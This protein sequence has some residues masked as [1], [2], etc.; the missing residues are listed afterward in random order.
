MPARLLLAPHRAQYLAIGVEPTA[1]T[2]RA[3][4][5][6]PATAHK[7]SFSASG[8][9]CSDLSPR[10][11]RPPALG[12][13]TA[14]SRE[15]LS[16][17]AADPAL[18]ADRLAS[19][20]RDRPAGRVPVDLRAAATAGERAGAGE[21]YSSGIPALRRPSKYVASNR[22]LTS[23]TPHGCAAFKWAML[24]KTS[25]ASLRASA[26]SAMARSELPLS[27]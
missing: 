11:S 15:T 26:S 5:A 4:P 9:Y 20:A 2:P 18:A 6:S 27:A 8:C 12:L 24:E 1:H 19:P 17:F 3:P 21:P 16:L 25:P 22:A 7:A 23:G 10:R 14:R 13:L